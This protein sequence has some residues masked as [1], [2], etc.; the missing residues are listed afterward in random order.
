MGRDHRLAQPWRHALLAE[1][2]RDAAAGIDA[3]DVH[4][5]RRARPFRSRL[6][7]S[8]RPSFA[9]RRSNRTGRSG[10]NLYLRG[11]GDPSLST[12]F[13]HDQEPMD[14]LAAE[15]AAAG[16]KHVRGDLVGDATAFDDKLVPDGWKTSYLGA[17][18]R[19]ARVRALA[20]REPRVGRGGT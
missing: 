2:R 19:G 11:M 5:G 1:R 6:P 14:V 10:G 9:T 17:V 7:R 15:I 12:R 13:W 16:I 20:Q 4:V 3:Q 8:R 18:V